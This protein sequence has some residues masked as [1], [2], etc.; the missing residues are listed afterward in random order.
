VNGHLWLAAALGVAAADRA[1]PVVIVQVESARDVRGSTVR[2]ALDEAADI[3]RAAG[4]VFDW[5][6]AGSAPPLEGPSLR[7]VI[8]DAGG[9]AARDVALGWIAFAVSDVPDPVIHLSRANVESLINRID[10][11]RQSPFAERDL[12]TGRALGRAL[13]HEIGHYLLASRAHTPGGLMRATRPS[14]AF[15]APARIGFELTSE[16]RVAAAARIARLGPSCG[17]PGT[18]RDARR[19]IASHQELHERL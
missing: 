15:F 5:R 8:D 4:I 1:R 12:L 9:P 11:L 18:D 16:Q 2:R 7:V 10:S 19:G 13:A 17:D 6:V 3:W 14:L